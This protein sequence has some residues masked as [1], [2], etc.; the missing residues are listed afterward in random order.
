MKQKEKNDCQAGK[1]LC[2]QDWEWMQRQNRIRKRRR[3]KQVFAVMVLLLWDGVLLY[4]IITGRIAV[5]YGA[6]F[7]AVISMYTGYQMK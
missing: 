5:G 6:I 1:Y 7:V 4:M 2:Q 3:C